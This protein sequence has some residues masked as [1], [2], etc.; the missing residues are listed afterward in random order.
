MK[1]SLKEIVGIVG[2]GV[3]VESVHSGN[4]LPKK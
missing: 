4:I 1:R 3:N 2:G